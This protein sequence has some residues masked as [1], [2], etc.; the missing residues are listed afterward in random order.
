[1]VEVTFLP[2]KLQKKFLQN[3]DILKLRLIPKVIGLNDL[4]VI[5]EKVNIA[6]GLS[7]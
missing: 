1:M 5:V 7:R 6:I 4:D 3:F 2:Q